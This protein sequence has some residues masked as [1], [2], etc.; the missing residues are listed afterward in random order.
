VAFSPDG[1]RLAAGGTRRTVGWSEAGRLEFSGGNQL[2]VFDTVFR[3]K[4]LPFREAGLYEFCVTS[5]GQVLGGER[6]ELRVL[7][8]RMS[9]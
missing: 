3:F 2:L 8:R 1:K 5:E 6:A 7:D 9:L 4:N